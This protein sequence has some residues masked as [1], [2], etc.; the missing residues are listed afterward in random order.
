MAPFLALAQAERYFEGSS[1]ATSMEIRT[2][3]ASLSTASEITSPVMPPERG[4]RG[5]GGG[6][7]LATAL[8]LLLNEF[9]SPTVGWAGSPSTSSDVAS[10]A[11]GV[12]LEGAHFQR[13]E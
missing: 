11:S 2:V 13:E 7:L 9:H 10:N 1:L 12:S 4:V 6:N 8:T 5:A 3:W